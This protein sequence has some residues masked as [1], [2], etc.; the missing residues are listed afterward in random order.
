MKNKQK[1]ISH[2]FYITGALKFKCLLFHCQRW[3]CISVFSIPSVSYVQTT[4]L[5][6]IASHGKRGEISI[7]SRV[8]C[9]Y[10]LSYYS[11]SERAYKYYKTTTEPFGLGMSAS[12]N[13]ILFM[14]QKPDFRGC[15]GF[16]KCERQSTVPL[17]CPLALNTYTTLLYL[18]A[19]YMLYIL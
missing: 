5:V 7:T 4:I 1:K 6:I 15:S 3:F 16:L 9:Y 2:H 13:C 14:K 11:W 18:S 12:A 10:I 19:S 8:S 17:L